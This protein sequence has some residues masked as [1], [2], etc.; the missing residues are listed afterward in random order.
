MMDFQRRFEEFKVEASELVGKVGDLLHE[1][2]V[3]RIIIKDA[4][5]N[6]FMEVPL[7]VAAIGVIAAP[8]VSAIGA[9]AALVANFTVVV[10]RAGESPA[11]AAAPPPPPPAS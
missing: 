6:T 2:N 1:G 10:E 5:G 11:P 4:S 7:N 9:L 8:V 3:R